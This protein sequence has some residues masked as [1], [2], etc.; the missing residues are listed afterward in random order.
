M[1]HVKVKWEAHRGEDFGELLQHVD[2]SPVELAEEPELRRILQ[3]RRRMRAEERREALTFAQRRRAA[4]IRDLRAPR[5]RAGTCALS[6]QND[7]MQPE[8]DT[9]GGGGAAAAAEL[10]YIYKFSKRAPRRGSTSSPPARRTWRSCCSPGPRR[11]ASRSRCCTAA[12]TSASWRG[13]AHTTRTQQS[14]SVCGCI[15]PHLPAC[16]SLW[17]PRIKV[18]GLHCTAPDMAQAEHELQMFPPIVGH[19]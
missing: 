5:A 18:R 2:A 14:T 13:P 11:W 19:H 8:A 1:W 10:Q 12:R 9:R 7:N 4:P 15:S 17:M 16:P 6:D 3:V